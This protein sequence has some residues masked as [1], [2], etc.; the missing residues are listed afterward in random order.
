MAAMSSR[1]ST[2]LSKFQLCVLGVFRPLLNLV[3]KQLGLWALLMWAACIAV[4]GHRRALG[5]VKN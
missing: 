5:F 3:Q 4:Q 2:L 1:H